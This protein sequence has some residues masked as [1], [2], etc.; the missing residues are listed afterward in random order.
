MR[1]ETNLHATAIVIG[2]GGVLFLGPSG[3]GKSSLAFSCMA[4]AGQA[5]VFTALIADD[6]VFVEDISGHVVAKRPSSIAGLIEIR[7]SGIARVDSID[8]AVIHLAVLIVDRA[9]ADRLPTAEAVWRL[10]IGLDLPLLH[11]AADAPAPF[12]IL[13]E[14]LAPST[15][16]TG[17]ESFPKTRFHF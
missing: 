10:P 1:I 5:Q 9:H 13:M 14:R 11:M 16:E 17:T 6:Q 12:S 2:T 3:A 7:H 15:R 8:A 4:A